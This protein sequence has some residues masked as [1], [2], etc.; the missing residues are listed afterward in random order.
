MKPDIQIRPAVASDAASIAAL[1]HQSFIEFQSSYTPAGFAATTPTSDQIQLRM[2]EGPVWVALH[3]E[4]IVGTVSVVPKEK[5]LYIRGMAVVPSARG[6][7]VGKALLVYVERAAAAEGYQRL[8]LSTT[9]FLS[10]AIRLYENFGFRRSKEAP[11]DLF[12]TPLF[13]MIKSLENPPQCSGVFQ[14]QD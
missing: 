14:K 10:A 11:P 1:L 5:G 2:K 8:F 13:T 9:P 12:G 6:L 3:N 4:A 7:G